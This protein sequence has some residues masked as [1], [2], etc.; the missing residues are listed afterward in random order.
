MASLSSCFPLVGGL[1]VTYTAALARTDTAAAWAGQSLF[2]VSRLATFVVL[3]A[4]L[5]ALGSAVALDLTWTQVLQGLA[6]LVMI[7]LGLQLL[8]V[9]AGLRLPGAGITTRARRWA[10]SARLSSG[11]LLGLA[12]F[13]LPCGFTQSM[14]LQA[15]A[16]GSAATG[17]LLLGSFAVGT[18]PVLAGLS[19]A[20]VRGFRGRGHELFART[21]GFLVLGLGLYQAVS[22]L[23]AVGLLRL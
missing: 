18:L 20:L 1:L 14:Q 21:A 15:L 19:T 8:G 4:G 23:K 17:A 5:G 2:H 11:V 22:L 3:G 6:V 13:F 9:F 10:A 7:G 16:S 12:S